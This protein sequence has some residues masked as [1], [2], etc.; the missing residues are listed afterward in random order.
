MD[1]SN[2]IVIHPIKTKK[3]ENIPATGVI[4][5]NPVDAQYGIDLFLKLGAEQ[6]KFHNSH[7]FV[8]PTED[9]FIA[10]PG[11]GAPVSVMLLEKLIALGA[12]RIF[13]F[14]WCGAVD[15]SLSL[16]DIFIPTGAV[17][18]E[19]TSQYYIS[20]E[21]VGPS[22]SVVSYLEECVAQL[23]VSPK[24]GNIWTTDAPYRESRSF[25]EKLKKEKGVVAVDMEFSAL[26]TVAA[27]R[28]V[29]FGALM[30]VSDEIYA[31]KWS[32]GMSKK[33][34]RDTRKSLIHNLLT[35]SLHRYTQ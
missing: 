23:D 35:N 25:L 27:F 28:E 3:E 9:F 30:L 31:E 15:R 11:I 8:H 32:S 26:C 5:V 12:T 14:G 4:L 2:D 19:G 18:G 10:G 24:S 6:R 33:H 20:G 16:C 1:K 21:Q 34:F 13:F 22:A 29:E 17:C 7:L